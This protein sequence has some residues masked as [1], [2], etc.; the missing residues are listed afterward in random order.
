MWI[1]MTRTSTIALLMCGLLAGMGESEAGQEV[2]AAGSRE[3][4]PVGYDGPPPPVPPEVIARD[5]AGRVTVRAV[6]I[7]TPLSI[8]G[9]LD[10]AVYGEVPAI[11]GLIQNEPMEGA[12]ASEK[13]EV[14]FFYDRD[15]FY[16]V[17]KCWETHP[18][19]MVANE[20]RRDN[21]NIVQN[22]QFAFTL[23]TFYDRRNA[24]LFEIGA[25]GGRIDGQI[26]NE[27]QF[28][29]DWNPVWE[30][31]VGR[32][33]GGWTVEAAV[34][35]KS[36]RYQPGP[37]QVWG[38]QV[39][40]MS[41]WRNEY[42]FLTEVPA[43]AGTAGHFRVS[44]FATL[45]GVEAPAGGVNLEIKP[46]AITDLTTDHTVSPRISNDVGGDAGLDV[47]YGIT[48]GLTADVTVNTDF[49][50]VEAD[51]EQVNL[52]RFSLFF[53][54]KREFFLENAGTY[55]FGGAQS[56]G[57]SAGGSDTPILFYSRQIGLTGGREVPIRAGGRVT[58]RVGRFS[59]GVLNVQ[60]GENPVAGTRAT[61]FSVIRVKR[62]LLRKSNIGVLF[63]GRSVSQ[64]GVGSNEAYGIDGT[65]SFFDDLAI[66]TYW[67]RTRT[68]GLTTDADS[69]RAQLDYTGDRYGVRVDHLAVGAG[70]NPEVG[71]ARR[72]DMRKNYGFFR[73]SPRTTS[74]ARV[75][76]YS[77]TGSFN[78][79]E[80][81]AGRLETRIWN[82]E[83]EA[84]FNNSD[85]FFVA[86]AANY[87]FLPQPFPIAQGVTLP[88]GGYD[89]AAGR[90]GYDFGSQR[91]LSGELSAE[92]GSFFNGNKTTVRA[93]QGRVNF[94]PQISVEPSVSINWVDLDQ[95]SFA[96]RLVTTR[97]TYTVTPLMFTTALLQYNSGTDSV[98]VNVRL[99]W[100]YQPGSE[101]F[102]VY[103]EQ[104]DT[105]SRS[106]PDI[107]NRAL[108]VK[109]NRLFRF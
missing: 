61:N 4:V 105:L 28:T 12:P 3:A 88:V 69:Y 63:T 62:D 64:R 74:S 44:L 24:F 26:T 1:V 71:F 89:F 95:G 47:K 25:A 79:I 57:R 100:E 60:A 43:S 22:D 107:Q 108:I 18:E 99:R 49:A 93:S 106:F 87:E 75:R 48:Q 70:F 23:D 92:Y 96:T 52:T 67:A 36:L 78:H 104:R 101:L 94:G 46:Y 19:R 37:A 45:V 29:A 85:R 14:W 68:D 73:F 98:A 58:G 80:N 91:N 13:T 17:G 27:R 2:A 20:M 9:R 6:R 5:A 35:F 53:P 31:V 38:I 33:E 86:Y 39:R 34:P 41:K 55:G 40:R 66:N 16:V 97:V 82:G 102:I 90:V 83:F 10:E 109:I 42:A 84:Q 7:E 30:T 103:S 50:Q 81:G 32:F 21:M 8:D 15:T 51:E 59:V 56:I 11:S 77:W 72:R 76:K 65:F 54:E